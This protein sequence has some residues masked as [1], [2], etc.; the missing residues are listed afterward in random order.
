MGYKIKSELDLK[1]IANIFG[2]NTKSFQ[3]NQEAV[4][5]EQY[6]TDQKCEEN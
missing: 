5:N 1:L 2:K 6:K 4:F 3:N